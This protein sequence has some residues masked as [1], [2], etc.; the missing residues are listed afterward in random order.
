[1][2]WKY[3]ASHQYVLFLIPV[4]Q[5]WQYYPTRWEYLHIG[6]DDSHIPIICHLLILGLIQG[7]LESKRVFHRVLG[8]TLLFYVYVITKLLWK[9]QFNNRR[10]QAK[11]FTNF[12]YFLFRED[13]S[14]SRL[15]S[16]FGILFHPT[17][18]KLS[19]FS[20]SCRNSLPAVKPGS[21]ENAGCSLLVAFFGK[22]AN[23]KAE[24]VY[25]KNVNYA[26]QKSHS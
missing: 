20:R 12:F 16:A 25:Y 4:A 9:E 7:S 24:L 11:F 5:K 26:F 6:V 18:F 21:Q 13:L 15:S 1:M 17:I 14:L 22:R 2:Y 23:G 10:V 3:Q 8:K 19:D